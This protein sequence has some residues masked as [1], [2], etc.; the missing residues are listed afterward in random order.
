M[1]QQAFSGDHQPGSMEQ[2]RD[3]KVPDENGYR[4]GR[5]I[6][7]VQAHVALQQETRVITENVMGAVQA[8]RNHESGDDEKNVH[9]QVTVF[10]GQSKIFSLASHEVPPGHEKRCKCPERIDDANALVGSW[11]L[12]VSIMLNAGLCMASI[13]KACDGRP[14][15]CALAGWWTRD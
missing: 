2:G 8:P 1:Q 7:R 11:C 14:N 13:T 5:Q 9:A 12:H 3:H 10:A 6:G 4:D 15:G